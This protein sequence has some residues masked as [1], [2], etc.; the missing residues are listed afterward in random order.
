MYV[1]CVS[2][3]EAQRIVDSSISAHWG[4]GWSSIEMEFDFRDTHYSL[5]RGADGFVYTREFIDSD[6]RKIKDVLT[7]ETFQRYI[8][9]EAVEVSNSKERAYRNSVN[10]VMYF[11]LLPVVLNDPAVK[12]QFIGDV[13]VHE[14]TYYLL[15]V[16]FKEEGGGDD[17]DD[18]YL[19]WIDKE[20]YLIE[21]LAYEFHV[22]GGGKRFR[23]AINRREINGVQFQDYNNFKADDAG[24]LFIVDDMFQEGKLEL[25]S[26]IIN[27]NVKINLK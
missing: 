20:T 27:E 6:S 15:Q 18:T 11:N 7:D 16:T 10:S 3:N 21:Y 19:Y 23:E 5:E 14:K 9:G 8:D 25:L 24:D 1:G 17:Y 2:D 4:D 26:E 22:D 13:Q 12:K